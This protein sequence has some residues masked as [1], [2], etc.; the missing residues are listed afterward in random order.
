MSGKL[1][2][3]ADQDGEWRTRKINLLGVVRSF[4]SQL[5]PGQDLTRVSLPAILLYPFSMLEVFG[6]RELAAFDLLLQMNKQESAYDRIQTVVKATLATIQQETFHKKPYNPVLGETHECYM[7]SREHGTTNFVAEQVSH[8]PPVSA[9]YIR[10]DQEGIDL[11]CNLSFGVR[12]GG[13]YVSIVTDGAAY[14]TCDKYGEQYELPRRT[15]DMVI[16]NVVWGTKR[17]YWSGELSISCAKTGYFANLAFKES[18]NDNVV[19]GTIGVITDSSEEILLTLEGKCGSQVY[20]T[21]R[22]HEKKL[23]FDG[24]ANAAQK[25]SVH[26]LN[27]TDPLSSITLW[28]EVNKY[29]VEDDMPKADEYKKKIEQAQRDRSAER[30][31]LGMQN[32]AKFFQQTETGW[33]FKS[34]KDSSNNN[35]NGSKKKK[36]LIRAEDTDSSDLEFDQN[37]TSDSDDFDEPDIP[38]NQPDRLTPAMSPSSSREPREPVQREAPEFNRDQSPPAPNSQPGTEDEKEEVPMKRAQKSRSLRG[39]VKMLPSK[40]DPKDRSSGNLKE[41]GMTISSASSTTSVAPAKPVQEL[42]EDLN[43]MT[44]WMKMRNS[45]KL[46][47]NRWFVLRPGKL[48]YYKDDKDM[49][50]DRCVGILKLADCEIR[51]RQTN[52]DGFSFKIYHVLHYPIYHKYG[53]RGETLKMAKLPVSWDYCI[54]RVSSEHERN[55][56]MEAISSQIEYAN[57]FLSKHPESNFDDM[58]IDTEYDDGTRKYQT[59]RDFADDLYHRNEELSKNLISGLADQ[60]KDISD[61][62]QKKTTKKLELWKKDVDLKLAQMEKKVIT[63]IYEAQKNQPQGTLHL[64]Y[65]QLFVVLVLCFVLGKFL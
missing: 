8:H 60:N 10:N 58:L 16:K 38:S 43:L 9:I 53:L 51:T 31:A 49:T 33:T 15:P 45:M 27:E 26:Y 5:R 25:K 4:V 47:I 18:G 21:D 14:I 62:L 17:I 30:K 41:L 7:E 1:I 29:I 19:N 44:G 3:L 65:F 63:T 35:N 37:Q 50:R 56:W 34:R 42:R 39:S 12:F 54:L 11:A 40:T 36:R 52:K 48:I 64:S 23:F 61:V 6:C 46:W 24:E 55:A 13:N 57:T 22:R 20:A 59:E 2:S 32:E 28:S